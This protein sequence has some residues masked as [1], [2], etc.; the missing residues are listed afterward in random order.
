MA[1]LKTLFTLPYWVRKWASIF[2]V[3]FFPS[4]VMFTKLSLFALRWLACRHFILYLAEWKCFALVFS[5]GNR[6]N[7]QISTNSPSTDSTHTPWIR[8]LNNNSIILP[9]MSRVSTWI[10][11]RV[12]CNMMGS[13]LSWPPFLNMCT[14]NTD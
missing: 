1:K 6:G 9:R 14:Y 13:S 5:P 7:Q 11:S 8:F 10:Q 12:I 3:Q 4:R 2:S